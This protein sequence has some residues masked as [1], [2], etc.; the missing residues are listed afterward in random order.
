MS[1]VLNFL[2]NLARQRIL[3]RYRALLP[4]IR[5]RQQ[6]LRGSDPAALTATLRQSAEPSLVD[7]CAN[8]LVACDQLEGQSFRILEENV[9]W[10]ILPF[11][12][13]ILGGLV[14]FHN[15]VAEMGTGEGKTLSAVVAYLSFLHKRELSTSSPPTTTWPSATRSG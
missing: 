13:Q 14:L 1:F 10:R 9:V 7:A 5:R 3:N 2:S 11:D 12:S 4:D 15:Q 8:V 6:A